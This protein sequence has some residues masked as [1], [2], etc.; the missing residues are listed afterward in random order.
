MLFPH[1]LKQHGFKSSIDALLLAAFAKQ[2]LLQTNHKKH[3]FVE[4]GVGSGMASLALALSMQDTPHIR[5]LGLDIQAE[6]INAAKDNAAALNLSSFLSFS[7]AASGTSK[8]L[9]QICQH[10][11]F[12]N[13]P[14]V[15]AN[16]PYYKNIPT[17]ASKDHNRALA[18]HSTESSLRDFCHTASCILQHHGFFC[19]VFLPSRLTEI[20]H[21][22]EKYKLGIRQILPIHSRP[23]TDARWICIQAQKNAC[24]D[25]LLRPSIYVYEQSHGQQYSSAI[26]DFCPWLY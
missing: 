12:S 1:G 25:I 19:V 22:L 24:T 17:R 2:C 4:L 23:H 7:H 18:L 9:R 10:E 8:E 26:K 14:L 11:G 6:A 5:G 16:P 15:I 13:V 3:I 20:C 21:L